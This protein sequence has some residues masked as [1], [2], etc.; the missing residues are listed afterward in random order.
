MESNFDP[1][2]KVSLGI[3]G[4]A[5]E[6]FHHA[7]PFTIRQLEFETP[8]D[9][10]LIAP[11]LETQEAGEI[12]RKLDSLNI[13]R[14]RIIFLCS[15][16]EAL[17]SI[18]PAY[19]RFTLSATE[20]AEEFKA[21][22]ATFFE[23]QRI[24]FLNEFFQRARAEITAYLPPAVNIAHSLCLQLQVSPEEHVQ[25]LNLT[26]H[27]NT[28]NDFPKS[29]AETICKISSRLTDCLDQPNLAREE[30]K[31]LTAQLPFRLRTEVRAAVEKT[32]E[33][34]WRSNAHVA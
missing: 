4:T 2:R 24:S 32:F 28:P 6:A 3:F 29:L 5:P 10:F 16:Q 25:A 27:L 23:L 18:D 17:N 22:I 31:N 19:G 26:F 30:L 7:T 14:S 21:R 33:R 13:Y 34:L 1:F 9:F 12:L 15:S 8:T 20:T 11:N